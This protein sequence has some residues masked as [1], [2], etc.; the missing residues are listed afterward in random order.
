MLGL[1]LLFLVVIA[2][3]IYICI[4]VKN[5][6]TDEIDQEIVKEEIAVKAASEKLDESMKDFAKETRAAMKKAIEE[7]KQNSA[8]K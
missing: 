2:A 8:S 1:I 4:V 5:G 6:D 3:I 7:S